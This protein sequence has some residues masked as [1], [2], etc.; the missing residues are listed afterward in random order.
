MLG[1]C[2]NYEAFSG[3]TRAA[4]HQTKT[5]RCRQAW[6]RRRRRGRSRAARRWRGL[7][8]HQGRQKRGSN[9][10]IF[11]CR[12]PNSPRSGTAG[13]VDGG[14]D[15][16]GLGGRG[17]LPARSRPHP[18]GRRTRAPLVHQCAAHVHGLVRAARPHLHITLGPVGVSPPRKH[19]P[20]I[21]VAILNR[22]TAPTAAARRRRGD[23]VSTRCVER[24]DHGLSILKFFLAV[25]DASA[26]LGA[27]SVKC[28][29]AA[30]PT[31]P[32][33]GGALSLRLHDGVELARDGL[34]PDPVQAATV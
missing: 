4:R 1:T 32:R 26:P 19:P 33:S 14:G 31:T 34:C 22:P 20:S 23:A 28:R 5:T 21:S 11:E 24:R 6:R 18:R 27:A 17:R 29:S 7:R 10:V 15:T 12:T 3:A 16:S 8:P 9:H 25:G 30:T 13:P 2:S